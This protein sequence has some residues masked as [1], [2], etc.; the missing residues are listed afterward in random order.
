MSGRGTPGSARPRYLGRSDMG[1]YYSNRK[2]PVAA[3][4]CSVTRSVRRDDDGRRHILVSKRKVQ[5]L[6]DKAVKVTVGLSAGQTLLYLRRRACG[7]VLSPPGRPVPSRRRAR[8]HVGREPELY[9]GVSEAL[10]AGGLRSM[11]AGLQCLHLYLLG[12]GMPVLSCVR[13]SPFVTCPSTI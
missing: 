11:A 2:I 9:G 5:L 1:R 6:D 7:S 13:V 4:S 8:G 3:R 12:R 10:S